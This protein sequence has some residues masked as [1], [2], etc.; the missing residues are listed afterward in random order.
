MN[1]GTSSR[2]CATFLI[3]EAASVASKPDYVGQGDGPR[4]WT[5]KHAISWICS[6]ALRKFERQQAP[7]KHARIWRFGDRQGNLDPQNFDVHR[8][9]PT[10]S[11]NF[12]Q[13]AS[14]NLLFF[15]LVP[16]LTP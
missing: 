10:L 9:R 16:K 7:R 3:G 13:L 2:V 8:Q 5:R 12:S 4:H 6:G 1:E 14:N 15:S 11:C